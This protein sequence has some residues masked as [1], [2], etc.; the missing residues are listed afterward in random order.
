MPH[1][2]ML[3]SESLPFDKYW[4]IEEYFENLQSTGVYIRESGSEGKVVKCDKSD[5]IIMILYKVYISNGLCEQYIY[6][7]DKVSIINGEL[8]K[9][10]VDFYYN[11]AEALIKLDAKIKKTEC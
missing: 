3:L 8:Q 6:Y 4:T 1:D 11:E 7:I 10:N 5:N 9:T 2:D